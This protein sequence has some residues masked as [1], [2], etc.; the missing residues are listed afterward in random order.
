MVYTLFFQVELSCYN[1]RIG[2]EHNIFE[3]V[4]AVKLLHY[5]EKTLMYRDEVMSTQVVIIRCIAGREFNLPYMMSI[6]VDIFEYEN[7]TNQK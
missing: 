4:I 7:D 6:I 1:V 3:A 2:V 5:F